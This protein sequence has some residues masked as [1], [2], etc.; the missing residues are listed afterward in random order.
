MLLT[1][2]G[3]GAAEPVYAGYYRGPTSV[4]PHGLYSFTNITD[5]AGSAKQIGSAQFVNWGKMAFDGTKYISFVR[6]VGAQQG[7][8]LYKFGVSG[9]YP[10]ISSNLDSGIVYTFT[11]W[12]GIGYC[13]PFFYG[14]YNGTAMSGPGLYRFSDP[15]DPESAATRLFAPQTFPSNTWSDMDFDGTRW[16]FV[17]TAAAGN[18]GIYQLD[19]LTTNFTCIGGAET[20]TSWDG[21]GVYVAP[22]PPPPSTNIPLLHKKIYVI[23]FGGQSNS[24]GWGYRQYLLDTGN[25]LAEPQMDVDF[26]VGNAGWLP[27]DTLLPLQSGA[28]NPS[29]KTKIDTNSTPAI[30][31]I[32]QQYTALTN[33][34]VNRF[35]PELS[36]GRTI[37]DLIHIP[38]SKVAVI[39]Y[40]IGGTSLHSSWLPNGT[41]NSATDGSVYQGFQTTVW[42][43][44]AALQ[45]QYPDYEIEIL[46]MG[47]VQGEA[48]AKVGP[49]TNYFSNLTNFM[50]DVRATFGTNLVFALSKLSPNQSTSTN[51]VTVRAAQ[52]AAAD[53]VYKVVA[54]ETIGTDYLTATASTEGGV[55]YL[56]ASLLQIG[57]DL[58]NAI[59]N[60][61]GL[62]IDNDGLP[63]AWE[64]SY[65][66]P[67]AAGL[68]N[69]PGADYDGDGLTDLQEFQA[70]TNPTNSADRLNLT[71]SQLRARWSAKKNVR[72]QM[73]TSTNLASWTEFGAPVLLRDSNS[74]AEVDFSPYLATNNSAFFRLQVR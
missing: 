20:Y 4:M 36:M 1:A 65:T 58:G 39:K 26:F 59:V 70:G 43:G 21:L 29:V 48:D 60:A 30:I 55:H 25:P 14:L 23:L 24:L 2:G 51:Y 15:T 12:H 45:T 3:T 41:T 6:V 52:Q 44:L 28:G 17:K 64:N 47:W 38:N 37:R 18:P 72:Y 67:G 22:E 32:M 49:D 66:P 7:P 33:A 42:N 56:S 8:G 11:N 63:D 35:G 69:S 57:R 40:S 53:T 13:N 10:L 54:T 71:G 73:L 9:G 46:G 34:P 62:D 68:G 19:P 50:A 5:A 61:S 31:T 27:I 74:T 16:L